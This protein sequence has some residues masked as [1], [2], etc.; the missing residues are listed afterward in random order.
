M[1]KVTMKKSDFSKPLLLSLLAVV[2]T[3][4]CFKIETPTLNRSATFKLWLNEKS[5]PDSIL[6]FSNQPYVGYEHA[7]F[8]TLIPKEFSIETVGPKANA[9]MSVD[10]FLDNLA[11]WL[12]QENV[13][14]KQS[15]N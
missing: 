4:E 3:A 5:L 2:F 15:L 14:Q 1:L 13:L 10:V 6:A 11:R 12:Y 7:V 9:I 8:K